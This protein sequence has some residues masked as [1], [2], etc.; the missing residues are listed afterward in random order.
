MTVEDYLRQ[1][2]YALNDEIT[3]IRSSGGQK[4][5]VSDGRYLGKRNELYVYS[6]TA[7]TEL[8]FPDE[9]SIDL[10]YQ[11]RKQAGLIISI[12]GF[13]LIIALQDYIGESIPTAILYTSPWFLLEELKK[14]LS[15][16]SL[17]QDANKTLV[18]QLLAKATQTNP[19]NIE[20]AQNLLKAVEKQLGSPI[21]YNEHQLR[22]VGQVLTN[23][24]SF[25]WGPPGTGKTQTLGITVA[26]LVEAGESVLVV[27]HSNVAVDVAML[28]VAK[29]LQRS[30]IYQTGKILRYGV[31]YLSELDKFPQLHVRGVVRQKNPRLID[32]IERLEDEK[33]TLIKQSRAESLT[34]KEKE[35]IKNEIEQVKR[36]LEP[37]YDELKQKES[38]LIRAS[39]VI[40]CTLSKATISS[41]V[42]QRSFD[43]VLVDEASMAYIP[44]CAF[45]SSLAKQRTA[46]FGDFRQLA[47]ISQADT[48]FSR[49]WL[50]RDIFDQAGIIEKV[51]KRQSDNR[52]VLLATQY[53]MH[54]DIAAIPNQLFYGG[55]LKNG[56]NVLEQ[57]TPIVSSQ[58]GIGHPLVFYDISQLSAYCY[59]DKES[60][61]RFNLVSALVAVKLAYSIIQTSQNRI[62]IV[63]PY[64]AQSRLINRLL[65]DLKLPKEQ[66]YVAT[67][68]RFQ[69]SESDTVLFDIVEGPPKPKAGKLVIGVK[70]STAMR[71][72]NVAVSRAKGKFVVLANYDYLQTHLSSVD[73]FRQLVDQVADQTSIEAI[74]WFQRTGN[75]FW[76]ENLPGLSFFSNSQSAVKQIENDLIGAR[77]EIVIAW[78]TALDKYHF[79]AH[80]LKRCDP[81]RVRFFITGNGSDYFF[82]IGLKNAQI[83]RGSSYNSM[84]IVGIDRKRLWVYI[85]PDTASSPVLRLDFSQTTKLLYAFWRLVPE[86]EKRE[87]IEE[88]IKK[89]KGPIGMPCPQCGKALWPQTGKYGPYLACAGGCGFTKRITEKDATDLARVMG[90]TCGNCGGQVKGRKGYDGIFLGCVNYP[91]CKWMKS[92]ES[93]I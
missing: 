50:E 47:P 44:H 73:S 26:A 27:A 92:I 88:K 35:R 16:L 71:L 28:S 13:D 9:T 12:G 37:L 66:I 1:F 17:R 48:P 6:F 49:N 64:N 58:P 5:Y 34:L 2:N 77:E 72:A 56:P 59:S 39:R 41:D 52:L 70:D 84:G 24:V 79:S 23:T 40:G 68:H 85:N 36:T 83:W 91:S 67:V 10:E 62:G 32:K 81:T 75:N 65:R 55:Q 20:R 15:E 14:R 30:P 8:H 80:I 29:N 45:V 3:A 38:E 53:R 76:Q 60:H 82:D 90:I 63:T 42:Y 25:I 54:P 22:A 19:P 7:D 33:R 43:A 46:I 69:G 11:G 74:T 87:T 61:S 89:G 21:N 31:T 4:T 18:A 51:N 78:P 93:L 86:D 57:T